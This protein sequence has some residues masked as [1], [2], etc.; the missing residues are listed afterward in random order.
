MSQLYTIIV[1][2]R[3]PLLTLAAANSLDL[4]G[5]R[6]AHV[7]T[8]SAHIDLSTLAQFLADRSGRGR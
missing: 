2:D 7:R 3:G 4:A 5:G 6:P 8:L 1:P